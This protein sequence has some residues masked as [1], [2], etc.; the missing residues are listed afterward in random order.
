MEIQPEIRAHGATRRTLL[1]L[2]GATTAVAGASALAACGIG[3]GGGKP[4]GGATLDKPFTVNYLT[5]F[6]TD[7]A[8]IPSLAA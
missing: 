1:R 3:A 6:A 7:D 4:A 2:A 5:F 8:R